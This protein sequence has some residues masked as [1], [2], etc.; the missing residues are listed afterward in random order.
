MSL[1]PLPYWPLVAVIAMF[2][3]AVRDVGGQS[4]KPPVK[5]RAWTTKSGVFSAAQAARGKD[6]YSG[7]CR[8]CHTAETHTG[9]TFAA[10]WT[11]KPLSELFG[12]IREQMPKNEPASLSDQEYVDVMSYVLKMNRMP[13]GPA[14]LPP[15][16]VP[17]K[18]IRI[19]L[20][21]T[22]VRKEK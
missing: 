7:L 19:D 12:F 4:A 1:R 22:S 21:R 10:K 11:G 18:R 3:V 6:I 5:A 2:C 17:M 9:Q 20:T 8:S 14:E 15:D 16:S 13:A